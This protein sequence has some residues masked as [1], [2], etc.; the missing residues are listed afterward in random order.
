MTR[1]GGKIHTERARLSGLAPYIC[2]TWVGFGPY[3]AQR[4]TLKGSVFLDLA[5][6]EGPLFH[7][8]AGISGNARLYNPR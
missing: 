1:Y 5:R 7:G 2:N 3:R 6:P 8:G 4:P